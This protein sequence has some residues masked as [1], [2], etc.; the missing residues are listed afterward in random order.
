MHH[1]IILTKSLPIIPKVLCNAVISALQTL[2]HSARRNIEIRLLSMRLQVIWCAQLLLCR[3]FKVSWIYLMYTVYVTCW[4]RCSVWDVLELFII[5]FPE[6]GHVLA[7]GTCPSAKDED[8]W[9]R[10]RFGCFS[11]F[12]RYLEFFLSGF[13]WIY[14]TMHHSPL[15]PRLKPEFPRK[16]QGLLH[17]CNGCLWEGQ[18]WVLINSIMITK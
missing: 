8:S 9:P 17:F 3:M 14:V 4:F 12:W 11:C 1:E 2:G 5:L 7:K 13:Q 16:I 6:E 10:A 15:I 18:N